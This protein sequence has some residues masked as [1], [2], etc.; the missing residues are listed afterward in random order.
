MTSARS[1]AWAT[2][3]M[4]VVSVTA[5]AQERT[6]RTEP[7]VDFMADAFGGWAVD[8]QTL[9]GSTRDT[10]RTLDGTIGGGNLSLYAHVP[11]EHID[12]NVS[13]SVST[14]WFSAVDQV[15]TGYSGTVRLA[16]AGL[17]RWTWEI[18]ESVSYDPVNAQSYLPGGGA[19]PA[20]PIIDYRLGNDRQLSSTTSGTIGY[21]P[22]RR[23]RIAF[24]ASY[25]LID[26]PSELGGGELWQRGSVGGRY[27]YE[28]TRYM[29][30]YAGYSQSRGK[31]TFINPQDPPPLV[32]EPGTSMLEP[33]AP[34]GDPVIHGM[35]VGVNYNR[36]LSISRRTTVTAR[37]GTG[38]ADD[39]ETRQYFLTGF[40]QVTRELGRTWQVSA[41]YDR[42]V[43]F[44]TFTPTPSM[45]EAVGAELGGRVSSATALQFRADAGRTEDLGGLMTGTTDLKSVSAAVQ[46]RIALRERVA[47]FTEYFFVDATWNGAWV[48]AV[49]AAATDLRRHGVQVGISFGT[50]VLGRRR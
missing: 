18:V 16:S 2:A 31:G 43:R 24:E 3:S 25:G 11:K 26:S 13:G 38:A 29:S 40:G 4:L 5:F 12:L 9:R 45:V 49:D 37:L 27:T 39:G 10:T 14:R 48:E 41:F 21:R 1:A 28:I 6:D 50:A 36:A 44:V 8:R 33:V 47:L 30:F 7:T 19:T 46:Y 42:A 34:T 32:A 15:A 23:Q 35:D 20:V 22:T 17:R